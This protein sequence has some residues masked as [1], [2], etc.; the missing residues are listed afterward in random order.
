MAQKLTD[1]DGLGSANAQKLRSAGVSD[2]EDLA[3]CDPDAIAEEADNLSAGRV[4]GFQNEAKRNAVTIMTGDDVAAEYDQLTKVPTGVDKMDEIL[5][6]G[7]ESGFLVALAG[8]TGSGKTQISF[9]AM[10]EAVNE[11]DKPA[12][13]VE[14][15]RGRYRGNRIAEMYDEGTQSQVYK[16]PAYGLDQQEMAYEKIKE[17]FGPNDISCVVVD[18]FTARFRMSDRFTGREDLPDRHTVMSRH[19]DKLDELAAVCDVPVLL[20]CQISSNPDQYGGRYTVYG[21]TLMHHMVNFVLMMKSRKGALSDVELRN[22][23]EVQDQEFE[24]QITG[25]GVGSPS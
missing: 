12:V 14:T 11:Y 21:G 24:I 4:R 19:L 3:G 2:L 7:W 25:D 20:T 13:Y 1:I 16:V 10:G 6:G 8:E 9:Q 17:E 5:G 18:S 23:P 22:H 15:E